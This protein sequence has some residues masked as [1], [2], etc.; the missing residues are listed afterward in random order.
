MSVSEGGGGEGGRG[1]ECGSRDMTRPLFKHHYILDRALWTPVWLDRCYEIGKSRLTPIPGVST[2]E[3]T[4]F[5]GQR[6]L[7]TII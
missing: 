7:I 1:R 2:T 5:P 6:R 3:Q 4:G